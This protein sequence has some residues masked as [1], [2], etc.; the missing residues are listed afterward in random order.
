M[1]ANIKYCTVW[2][3]DYHVQ[4]YNLIYCTNYCLQKYC[5]IYVD[6]LLLIPLG[7]IFITN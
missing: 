7:V 5:P 6:D 1:M 4:K 2:I 3:S